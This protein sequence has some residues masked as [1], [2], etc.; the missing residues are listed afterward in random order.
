MLA[1]A[2]MGATAFQKG[3]GGMHAL[4][5]PIGALFGTHHGLTN[6]VLMPYVLAFN[7]PAVEERLARLAAWIGLADPGFDSFLAW[8][9]DLRRRLSI[10]HTLAELGV[11]PADVDRLALMAE[12]DPSAAGNPRRF[13]AE[14][15]R[16]ILEAALAGRV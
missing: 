7:R 6:A 2:A 10:P 14:A 1:A 5:H 11:A 12:Q 16:Q 9:L 3:L 15:A 4:S 8:I 13:D